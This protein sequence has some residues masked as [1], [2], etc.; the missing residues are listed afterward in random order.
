MDAHR[1]A[2]DLGDVLICERDLVTAVTGTDEVLELFLGLEAD[3]VEDFLHRDASGLFRVDLGF[4]G[5]V[6]ND[7]AVLI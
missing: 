7:L 3:L 2:G 4:D 5:G 1:V 6:G